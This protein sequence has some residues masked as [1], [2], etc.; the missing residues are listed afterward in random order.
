MD[1]PGNRDKTASVTETNSINLAKTL[2]RLHMLPTSLKFMEILKCVV[3]RYKIQAG[4]SVPA[5]DPQIYI[6]E[7][8][9][10]AQRRG[11]LEC[12]QF[13]WWQECLVLQM[14]V[15]DE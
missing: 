11:K 8:I 2:G 4:V 12:C 1:L 7:K 3:S 6:A 5:S 15:K 14:L 13:L 10:L 9:S